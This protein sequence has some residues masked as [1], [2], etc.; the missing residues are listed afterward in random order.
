MK[1]FENFGLS[2]ELMTSIKQLGFAEPTQ[3][4]SESI[5]HV[6]AGKDVIGESATGSGKTLAFGCG[7]VDKTLPRNGLQS[8][9][10]APTRELAEQVCNS[11]RKSTVS[12]RP[13]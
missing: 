2:H 3:I 12:W 8:L 10:L 4:Q 5:P 1:L 11:I 7:V 6:I 9:I 13:Q